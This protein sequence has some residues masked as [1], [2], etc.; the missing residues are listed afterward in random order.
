MQIVAHHDF[1]GILTAT[2]IL[3]TVY[4]AIVR[5]LLEMMLGVL[6]MRRTVSCWLLCLRT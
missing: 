6:I 1:L 3:I 2:N 5:L 4:D